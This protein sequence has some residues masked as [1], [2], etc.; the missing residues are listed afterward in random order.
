MK[1]FYAFITVYLF[2]LVLSG[3][4]F[5]QPSLENRLKTADSIYFSDPDS[6]YH[7]SIETETIASKTHDQKSLVIAKIYEARYLLLKSS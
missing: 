2:S 3:S 6:S 4:L 1:Q 5:G 7:L